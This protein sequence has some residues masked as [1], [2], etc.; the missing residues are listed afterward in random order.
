M[1]YNEAMSPYNS[2]QWQEEMQEEMLSL[3][4][5]NTWKLLKLPPGYKAIDNHCVF[6]VKP[7][8]NGSGDRR[9]KAVL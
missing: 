5:N 4:E 9:S 8:R 3:E 2:K 1:I 6:H 7:T